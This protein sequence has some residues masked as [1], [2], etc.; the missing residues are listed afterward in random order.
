M[1]I[2]Y[3]FQGHTGLKCRSVWLCLLHKKDWL[4]WFF[5]YWIVFLFDFALTR[6]RKYPA[7]QIVIPHYRKVFTRVSRSYF[8]RSAY[9]VLTG[10]RWVV[11]P[12][13]ALCF[14]DSCAGVDLSNCDFQLNLSLFLCVSFPQ[15]SE[16]HLL[17]GPSF[18][19]QC[20][21]CSSHTKSTGVFAVIQYLHACWNVTVI[22]FNDT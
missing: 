21:G 1:Q 8:A 14:S 10:K 4:F 15:I 6:I 5:I 22:C 13:Q 17:W 18:L 16:F 11:F 12:I 7:G 20:L 19:Q 9:G 2:S 3:F